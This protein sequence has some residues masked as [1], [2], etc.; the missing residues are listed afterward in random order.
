MWTR[1]DFTYSI[2]LGDVDGVFPLTLSYSSES[3]TWDAEASWVGLGWNLNVGALQRTVNGLPDDARGDILEEQQVRKNQVRVGLDIQLK[4]E[5]WGGPLTGGKMTILYDNYEGISIGRTYMLGGLT[6]GFQSG[7]G[8]SVSYSHSFLSYV[9]KQNNE[10]KKQ[11]SSSLGISLSPA[12][13]SFSLNSSWMEKTKDGDKKLSGGATLFSSGQYVLGS[14]KF[15]S[16]SMGVNISFAPGTEFFG[17]EGLVLTGGSFFFRNFYKK[18]MR[19]KSYG[20]LYLDEGINKE[21]ARLDF[22]Y[23]GP[24]GYTP[25][26]PTIAPVYLTPD[27]YSASAFGLS[28][29]FRP[30]R[31]NIGFVHPQLLHSG[32]SAEGDDNGEGKKILKKFL[33]FLFGK[34][35]VENNVGVSIETGGGG[36]AKLGVD[37]SYSYSSSNTGVWK[38]AAKKLPRFKKNDVFWKVVNGGGLINPLNFSLYGTLNE[39]YYV[40]LN[41]NSITHPGPL[42]PYYTHE[43]AQPYSIQSYTVKQCEDYFGTVFPPQT[44]P[45]HIGRFDIISPDGRRYIFDK[46]LYQWT[47][48][49]TFR[50][51]HDDRTGEPRVITYQEQDASPDNNQGK[52]HLYTYQKH[53]VY[54]YAYLPTKI[55]GPYYSD[56]NDNGPDTADLGWWAKLSY[57]D[58][59]PYRWRDPVGTNK[60]NYSPGEYF[61]NNDGTGSYTFGYKQVAYLTEIETPYTR[62]EFVLDDRED[63]LGVNENGSIN[64]SMKLKKLD[65]IIFY[66]RGEGGQ[67]FKYREVH[68]EHDYILARNTP[69]SNASGNRR[70]TLRKVKIVDFDIYGGFQT[71]VKEYSFEYWYEG[72]RYR[73]GDYD[74]VDRW[75]VYTSDLTWRSRYATQDTALRNKYVSMWKLKR[76]TDPY[77]LIME[78]EYESDRYYLYV[79]NKRAQRMYR[80]IRYE[81]SGNEAILTVDIGQPV[82]PEVERQLFEQIKQDDSLV[83]VRIPVNLLNDPVRKRN[84][85]FIEVFGK[86]VKHQIHNSTQIK[87]WLTNPV[88]SLLSGSINPIQLAAINYTMNS[89]TDQAYPGLADLP[90]LS[91]RLRPFPHRIVYNLREHDC[92]VSWGSPRSN[93]YVEVAWCWGYN[94]SRQSRCRGQTG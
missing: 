74:F 46:P 31:R 54:A 3:V 15:P 94:A 21:K 22:M 63:A 34:E 66:R 41:G 20:Y 17:A 44:K 58:T 7:V 59:I 90:H 76:I 4:G 43:L 57:T 48:Q 40:E 10:I 55:L 32:E 80:I 27:M 36:T 2:E 78:I 73:N 70:L 62:V 71:G 30:Q 37:V 47:K 39:P 38:N 89:A 9:E 45:H 6:M 60:A 28:L 51:E 11:Y 25:G 8:P 91:R 19:F 56:R 42:P 18:P 65:K 61:R 86:Y 12:S 69:N 33:D 13:Y 52:D 72:E 87:I 84:F 83:Y 77:G 26:N 14:S 67:W 75:G 29:Q 82:T 49:V 81:K 93:A 79:Q 92:S 53:P 16:W 85:S 1:G 64:S 24:E 50:I 68:F 5:L 23:D 35:T 88:N